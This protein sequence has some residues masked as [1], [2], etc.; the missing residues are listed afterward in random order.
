MNYCSWL[1][2][3]F[4]R[5]KSLQTN[6]IISGKCEWLTAIQAVCTLHFVIR[7]H[8]EGKE[9][10]WLQIREGSRELLLQHTSNGDLREVGAAM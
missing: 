8:N 1:R 7:D 2:S 5:K 6:T 9:E 10:L 3:F 4:L